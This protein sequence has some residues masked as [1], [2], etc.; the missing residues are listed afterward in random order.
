MREHRWSGTEAIDGMRGAAILAVLCYHT[1]L[2]SW[3]TP[4]L[5][6]FGVAIPVD[7]VPRVGY[8]GVDLFFVVS[9]FCLFYP[10]AR[11]ALGGAAAPGLRAF[12]E[13]RA[14][15]I[16]PSYALAVAAT[17]AVA[18]TSDWSPGIAAITFGEHLLFVNNF[19]NDPLGMV[20]SVFWTLAIEVQ[21]YVVF[22]LLA[23]AARRAPLATVGAMIACAVAF[24]YWSA[25]CCLLQET[26][27]RQL[28][29]YLDVFGAGMLAAFGVARV[30]RGG[31]AIARLAP[32]ATAG[33]AVL[34][35]AAF[36]LLEGANAVQYV[37]GGRERWELVN[38]TS[39]ALALGGF[40]F[41]ACFAYRR[42]RAAIANP[43]LRFCSVISY[44]LYLWHTLL[45]I[46]MWHHGVPPYAT[47]DAHDD[48][49]WK[50]AFIAC[51]WTASIAVASAVTYVFERPLL[52]TVKPHGFAFPWA[53]VAGAIRRRSA[54]PA[55]PPERS[56]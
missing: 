25:S 28:P 22:P 50:P 51:G 34:A 38:R 17:I 52:S 14:I 55:A 6:I 26:A 8:L 42:L 32:A 46:W 35:V 29:G 19:T 13:R 49:A 31:R 16:V 44:N 53:R 12:A 40:A 18:W 4:S 48:D 37:V 2:F 43:A 39:L 15:K 7:V 24:R 11:A 21:F 41:C 27:T 45:M 1:W 30:Q 33:C 56:T 3:F 10:E 54:P 36:A 5:S 23:R 47:V 20:N 9:G